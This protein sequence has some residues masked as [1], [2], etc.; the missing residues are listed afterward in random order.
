MRR[1]LSVGIGAA[2]GIAFIMTLAA[3]ALE[4]QPQIVFDSGA[5]PAF[6]PSV[7]CAKCHIDIFGY[8]KDSMHA[9]ALDDSIF[10]AA[11][12]QALNQEGDN[13]REV[14][15]RCHAPTAAV[16][17]DVMLELQITNEAITCDFCHRISQIDIKDNHARMTLTS[18]DEKYGPLQPA[19]VKDSH[20]SAQSTSF[21]DSAFCATCHQWSNAQGVPVFDTYREWQKGPYADKGIHCQ[22]CHMPLVQGAVVTN[23]SHRSTDK[24][25]S[26]NLSGGH[27]IVQVASAATVKIASL[28]RIAGGLEAVVE[29]TNV[30]S[31]HMIPTGIPSRQLILEVQLLDARGSI[32]RTEEHVFS[33]TILDRNHN[34]LTGD[35]NMILNGAIVSKDNRIPPGETVSIPFSFAAAPQNKYLV[36]AKL[37]Y[38]YKPLVLK[39][40]EIIIE[41]GSDIEG[42]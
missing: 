20:P 10:Q 19:S 12:M 14:C 37:S 22:N 39:E 31:G 23:D 38:S 9:H 7:N 16:T 42:T 15:L 17:G 30:G 2:I 21:A 24:I 29:V 41:M 35:A 36:K 8:W 40:E 26:H 4:A 34:P 13:I 28:K 11:F 6:D 3:I 1:T 33:R 25:N 5:K 18:G 32:V 27:S